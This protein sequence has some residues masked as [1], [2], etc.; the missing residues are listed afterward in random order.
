MVTCAILVAL[1]RH[2]HS[3]F[4]CKSYKLGQYLSR[5]GDYLRLLWSRSLVDEFSSVT[6]AVVPLI[7]PTSAL[8]SFS[9][10]WAEL[11]PEI[12][13]I[14]SW[15][16]QVSL[17]L[18]LTESGPARRSAGV[19]FTVSFRVQKRERISH[20]HLFRFFSTFLWGDSG[21]PDKVT[22]FH[23]ARLWPDFTRV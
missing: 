14:S 11:H 18:H 16:L 17:Q 6:W 2:N 4:Y 8:L 5:L 22:P 1:Y 10:D 21:S 15:R 20:L 23:C 3:F 12:K 19:F 13:Q 9:P 7:K